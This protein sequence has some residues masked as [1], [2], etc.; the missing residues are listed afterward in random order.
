MNAANIITIVV[1]VVAALSAYASQRAASRA[2]ILNVNTTSR[3][4]ME[5]EAYERARKFDTDTIT[6]QDNEIMELRNDNRELHEKVAEARAE[7]HEARA[8]A[9]KVSAINDRLRER[10]L[11]L[12]RELYPDPNNR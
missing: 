4:D 3:I 8:E 12:E 1:A 6:R 5:R 2:S 11:L 9:R 7:A 10:I